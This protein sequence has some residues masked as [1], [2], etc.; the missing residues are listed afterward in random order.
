MHR[1]W[2]YVSP[3]LAVWSLCALPSCLSVSSLQTAHPMKPG[4]FGMF[5]AVGLQSFS[6]S[7]NLAAINVA[8]GDLTEVP[9]LELGARYGI[10]D[11]IDSEIK[12]TVPGVISFLGRFNVFHEMDFAITPGLSYGTGAYSFGSDQ[13]RSL[14]VI[15]EI[16]I[17]VYL[18][19]D[20]T[21]YFSVF[22]T[23]RLLYRFVDEEGV[24]ESSS[25]GGVFAA[26]LGVSF[27]GFMLEV[28]WFKF[29]GTGELS[30]LQL[31]FGYTASWDRTLK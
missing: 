15:N 5:G 20:V 21:E 12:I 14:F 22:S 25:K 24:T 28:G 29:H 2:P 16:S 31:A 1:V 11:R 4:S 10:T 8:G 9:L 23:P 6:P 19:Y 13:A 18:S 3:I 17:P 7:E 27:F 30:A 26:T